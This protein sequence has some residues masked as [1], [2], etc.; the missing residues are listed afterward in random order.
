MFDDR[1]VR[2][3]RYFSI[4]KFISIFQENQISTATRFNVN[5]A[6]HMLDCFLAEVAMGEAD[7]VTKNTN[8]E[9]TATR[10]WQWVS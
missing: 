9:L 8:P 5:F 4:P 3:W 1:I 6:I 2:R 7:G 10:H